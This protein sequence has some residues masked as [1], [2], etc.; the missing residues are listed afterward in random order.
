M[1]EY[2]K[3]LSLESLFY[4]NDEGLVC[5]EVFNTVLNYEDYKCSNLGRVMSFK[6]KE[7]I[8]LKQ[9]LIK[10]NYLSLILCNKEGKKVLSVH[11][12][13]AMAFLGHTPCGYK[14]IVDHRIEDNRLDNRLSNLQLIT[15]RGNTTKSIKN[16]VSKYTGVSWDKTVK[17][18]RSAIHQ[19]G[20]SIYL[21]VHENEVD[22]SNAYKVALDKINNGEKIQQ[23][24]NPTKTSKYKGVNWDKGR[25]KWL[26]R[27]KSKNIGRFLDEYE[28]HLAYQEALEIYNNK[29]AS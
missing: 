21:G 22:A 12:I 25:N 17:K 2:Y 18:W 9:Y 7:A 27:F 5:Q 26:V 6:K 10:D 19:D 11:Q 29:K 20:K 3:N 8:I 16:S 28:A 1:I 24:I 14:I 23:Y 13:V 4:I 15:P